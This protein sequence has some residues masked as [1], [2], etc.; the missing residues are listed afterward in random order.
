[1]KGT[2]LYGIDKW[3]ITVTTNTERFINIK[4]MIRRIAIGAFLGL[5]WGAALRAWMVLLALKFGDVPQFT[6][7]G[8]FGGILLPA[9]LLGAMTGVAT[10][11]AECSDKKWWR[12][13]TL[14]PLLLVLGPLIVTKDFIPILL[15]TGMGG[16]AIGVAL[17]GMLGGYAFSGFG[18]Q[19]TRWICGILSLIFTLGMAYG[20]YFSAGSATATIG[21]SEVFGAMLFVLLMAVLIVGINTPSRFKNRQ[22]LTS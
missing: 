12:W 19:W 21:V 6:W 7:G 16:G 10:Y 1:L 2:P 11:V 15:T 3:R 13:A 14:L 22:P 20:L 17:I 9:A 4:A 8:T 5:A 18:A